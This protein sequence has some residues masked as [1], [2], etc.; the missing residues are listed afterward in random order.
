MCHEGVVMLPPMSHHCVVLCSQSEGD[1][2]WITATEFRRA[3]RG[4]GGVIYLCSSCVYMRDM[5]RGSSFSCL[6]SSM[7][8]TWRMLR[9]T[10]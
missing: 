8:V 4:A 1:V 7:V 10:A 3:C 9:A 6:Y 5:V 2:A